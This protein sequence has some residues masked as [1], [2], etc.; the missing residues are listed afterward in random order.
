LGVGRAVSGRTCGEWVWK[1]STC[2]SL[3][4]LGN[5][6]CKSRA[7]RGAGALT[8]SMPPLRTATIHNIHAC[9][10]EGAAWQHAACKPPP[11]PAALNAVQLAYKVKGPQAGRERRHCLLI[12]CIQCA[13]PPAQ[14]FL[15]MG[16]GS[17]AAWMSKEAQPSLP[18]SLLAPSAA[19]SLHAYMSSGGHGGQLNG[20]EGKGR[21]RT[22]S[23]MGRPP[24]MVLSVLSV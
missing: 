21:R 9:V 8:G 19:R 22:L 17:A 23:C 3:L 24:R 10:Q 15:R 4:T 2:P 7:A 5:C 1:F 6:L 14:D 11:Q 20:I 13:V 12:L 16:K 18:C